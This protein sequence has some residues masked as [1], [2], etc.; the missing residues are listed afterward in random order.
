MEKY[1]IYRRCDKQT[2]EVYVD[3]LVSRVTCETDLTSRGQILTPITNP[4]S[5]CWMDCGQADRHK[6]VTVSRAIHV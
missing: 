2:R 6:L 5:C 3:P 1:E 4:G